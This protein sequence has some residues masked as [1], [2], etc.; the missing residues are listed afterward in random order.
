LHASGPLRVLLLQN[1]RRPTS[2][3]LSA[4]LEGSRRTI[5]RDLDALTEAGLPMVGRRNGSSGSRRRR[6]V[7]V[8]RLTARQVH[9]RRRH[10]RC[11]EA[12]DRRDGSP[13]GSAAPSEALRSRGVEAGDR[14]GIVSAPDCRAMGAAKRPGECL[15]DDRADPN[16]ENRSMNIMRRRPALA[17]TTPAVTAPTRPRSRRAATRGATIAT[18]HWLRR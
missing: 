8:R 14:S 10:Q 1:R 13:A 16:R 12:P 18:S 3:Q 9:P 7:L 2:A 17:P 6:R 15:S 11:A 5:L 4:E